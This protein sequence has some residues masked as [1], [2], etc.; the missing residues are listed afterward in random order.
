MET[1]SLLGINVVSSETHLS[2]QS[3]SYQFRKSLQCSCRKQLISKTRKQKSRKRENRKI[4]KSR[5]REKLK[6]ENQQSRN[7]ETQKMRNEMHSK[8]EDEIE[9]GVAILNI[10]KIGK[11]REGN[12]TKICNHANLCLFDTE[13]G[14]LRAQ[15]DVTRCHQVH[16]S[17]YAGPVDC[18]YHYCCCYLLLFYFVSFLFSFSFLPG[19]L[20]SRIWFNEF[21][22]VFTCL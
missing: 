8:W 6:I 7:R 3:S 10:K 4:E 11:K 5:N 17:S 16:P 12:N 18:C 1:E 22:S 21:W 15:P 9:Y 20:H 19:F 13:G 14:I 2:C